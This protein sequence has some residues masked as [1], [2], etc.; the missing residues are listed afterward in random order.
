[1]MTTKLT[2]CFAI[3][4]EFK[5]DN[6]ELVEDF[7]RSATVFGNQDMSRPLQVNTK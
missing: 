5:H 2:R 4:I 6:E 7:L 3:P 1:M